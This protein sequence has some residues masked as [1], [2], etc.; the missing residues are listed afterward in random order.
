MLPAEEVEIRR[1]VVWAAFGRL[2]H[3]SGSWLMASVYDKI[4]S[5]YQ[6]RPVSFDE[7]QMHVSHHFLDTYEEQELWTPYAFPGL[8]KYPGAPARAISTFSSLCSL[9]VIMGRIITHIYADRATSGRPADLLFTF[10]ASLDRWNASMPK[11]IQ[12]EPSSTDTT[13]PPHILSLQ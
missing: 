3:T 5:L 1:R 2:S 12:Y 13:P 7:E 4:I 10:S 9:S 11:S 8:H 6:G